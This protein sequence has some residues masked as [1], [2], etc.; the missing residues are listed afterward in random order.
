M[1]ARI[2]ELRL[3]NDKQTL[4]QTKVGDFAAW[5]TQKYFVYISIGVI[6]GSLH[7]PLNWLIDWWRKP[8]VWMYVVLFMCFSRCMQHH[9]VF[10]TRVFVWPVAGWSDCKDSRMRSTDRTVSY[11]SKQIWRWDSKEQRGSLAQEGQWR[12]TKSTVRLGLNVHLYIC[13]E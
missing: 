11:S 13:G 3:F 7:F 2:E 5:F 12:T 8:L 1:Q 4:A 9:Q 6:S 10:T